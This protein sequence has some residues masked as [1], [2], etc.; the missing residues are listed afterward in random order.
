MTWK[1]KH[2]GG[3]FLYSNEPVFL[4]K[5]YKENLGC[6]YEYESEDKLYCLSLFYQDLEEGAKRYQVFSIGK[7]KVALER[8][9]H[10]HFTLNLRVTNMVATL[11]HLR[12]KGVKTQGPEVHDEGT[13]AW[14]KDPEGNHIEL[15]EDVS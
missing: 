12:E 4:A 2:I 8:L 15:W 13:F 3:I 7:S 1:V 14:L 6:D 9:T 5:W 10:K 11:A